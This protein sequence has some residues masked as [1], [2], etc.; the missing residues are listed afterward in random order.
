MAAYESKLRQMKEKMFLRKLKEA[1]KRSK[2][3]K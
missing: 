1:K 3:I 2:H